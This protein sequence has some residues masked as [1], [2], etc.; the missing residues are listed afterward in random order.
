MTGPDSEAGAGALGG[1]RGRFELPEERLGPGLDDP[2]VGPL[3]GREA[4]L[5]LVTLSGKLRHLGASGP[6]RSRQRPR[7]QRRR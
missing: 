7:R 4:I 6:G 3:G 2:G 5:E 1:D